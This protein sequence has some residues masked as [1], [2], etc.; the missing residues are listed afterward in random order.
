MNL[1]I[2][3]KKS[4]TDTQKFVFFSFLSNAILQ[5]RKCPIEQRG[6]NVI[7]GLQVQRLRRTEM[8]I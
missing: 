6:Q 7:P 5:I 8:Y 1:D 2:G 3:S 4:S